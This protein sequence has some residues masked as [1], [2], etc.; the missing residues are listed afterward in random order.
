M[1]IIIIIIIII[2]IRAIFIN[3]YSLYSMGDY[4]TGLYNVMVDRI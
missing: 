2:I 1:T 3:T 4:T